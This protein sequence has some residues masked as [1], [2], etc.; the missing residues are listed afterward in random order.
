MSES[1]QSFTR[2]IEECTGLQPEAIP[3]GQPGDLLGGSIVA[4]SPHG[5]LVLVDP[6]GQDDDGYTY[7]GRAL[8]V[9]R[10]SGLPSADPSATGAIHYDEPY[11]WA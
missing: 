8:L 6:I 4:T 2:R 7:Y 9:A 1:V 3:D 5:T 10:G 11:P